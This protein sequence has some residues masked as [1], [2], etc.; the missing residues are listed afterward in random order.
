MFPT[1]VYMLNDAAEFNSRA[2]RDYFIWLG[3]NIKDFFF[4]AGLPV[5]IIYIYLA[6][7]LFSDRVMLK[8]ILHWPMENIYIVT[9][10][11]TLLV[12]DLLG[13]NRGEVIRLW[14]YMAVFFQIPAAL[15]MAKIRKGELMLFLVSGTL[16]VQTVVLLQ[17]VGFVLP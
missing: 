13:I 7:R 15:L 11:V 17:R 5:M 3:E 9:L 10:L 16:F 1:F 2:D 12:V 14:I 8:D 4:S 6:A